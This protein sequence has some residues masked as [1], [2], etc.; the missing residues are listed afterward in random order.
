MQCERFLWRG[1]KW[2]S[3]VRRNLLRF[4]NKIQRSGGQRRHVQRLANMAS[5]I[6][7]VIVVMQRR[8]RREV[9]QRH[10]AQD[11]QRPPARQFKPPLHSVVYLTPKRRNLDGSPAPSVAYFQ[12]SSPKCC[13]LSFR[14]AGNP[15]VIRV[16]LTIEPELTRPDQHEEPDQSRW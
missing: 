11:R 2:E 16:V 6:R 9:Q 3:R 8:A 5:G 13:C 14:V 4:G 1:L 15:G 7:A 10:A 12:T